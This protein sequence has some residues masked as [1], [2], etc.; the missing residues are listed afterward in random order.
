M[1]IRSSS[2]SGSVI[3][4]LIVTIILWTAMALCAFFIKPL[5]LQ[6]EPEY[7]EIS[8]NLADYPLIETGEPE[9]KE[10]VPEVAQIEP[11]SA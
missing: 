7:I 1:R 9:I 6:K 5:N 11:Q 3:G 2:D 4:I 8:I 10:I